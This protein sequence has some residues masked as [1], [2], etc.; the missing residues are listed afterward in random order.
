MGHAI[1]ISKLDAA[2]YQSVYNSWK[3]WKSPGILLL[4]LEKFI[5]DSVIFVHSG[6]VRHYIAAALLAVQ[7]AVLATVIPSVCLSVCTSVRHTLVPY[8]DE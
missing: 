1:F 6:T 8:P 7:S 5:I 4:L 2:E 3:Y